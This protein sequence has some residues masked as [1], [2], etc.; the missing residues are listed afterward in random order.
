M[1]RREFFGTCA[2]GA[3]AMTGK[4]AA[5]PK[6]TTEAVQRMLARKFKIHDTP[7]ALVS[8]RPLECM[9]ARGLA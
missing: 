7:P 9:R 6:I 3:I 1:D 2:A 8:P 4:T 5:A